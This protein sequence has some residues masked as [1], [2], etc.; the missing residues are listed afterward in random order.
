MT[1]KKDLYFLAIILFLLVAGTA[2]FGVN[3]FYLEESRQEKGQEKQQTAVSASSGNSAVTTILEKKEGETVGSTVEYKSGEF[4]PSVVTLRNNAEH[5]GCF[6]TVVNRDYRPLL[7]RLSPHTAGENWGSL[8]PEIP[9]G[10]SISIDPRYRIPKIAYH[11]HRNPGEEFSVILEK[12][13][14]LN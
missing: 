8:Y 9:A 6:L 13:C 7:I 12:E 3:K 1:K 4:T 2:M 10:G 5:T 14:G 11:D